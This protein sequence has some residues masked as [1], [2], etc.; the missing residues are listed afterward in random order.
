MAV[1]LGFNWDETTWPEQRPF[2]RDEVDRATGGRAA[3]LSRVDVHSAVLSSAFLDA[4]PDVVHAEG[5]DASGLV[6]RDAHHAAR[7]GLFGLTPVSDRED[8]ILRALTEAARQGI[9]MV[10]ELGAPHIC[11]PEDLAIATGLTA[12]AP[13]PEVV[14]Y[15]GELGARRQGASSSAARVRPETCAWTAR[16]ARAPP[17]CT[18]PTPTRRPPVTSTSTPT[19]SPRTSWRAPAPGSRPAST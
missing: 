11:P 1:I 3:F 6:A 19:R 17:R 2:T 9:G 5:Y 15:W 12:R 13:L 14:G 7:D 10:H 18:R 8:A 4:C 16:S